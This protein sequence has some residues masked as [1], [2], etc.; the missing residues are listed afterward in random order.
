MCNLQ[1]LIKQELSMKPTPLITVLA[2]LGLASIGPA[3]AHVSLEVPGA[4][5]GST[6]KAVLRVP[7]GCDGKAT[8][9]VKVRIPEGFINVK[10]MPKAGWDLQTVVSTYQGS[11]ELHGNTLTEGVTEVVWSGGELPDAY[12]D[13][14]V[15][16]GTV[17]A[18]VPEGTT[19]FFP[20]VQLCDGAEEAWIDVTGAEDAEMPAP[21]LELAP[22]GATH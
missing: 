2:V 13:E 20:T 9:A 21:S 7:H 17:A 6:Y 4:T 12:Y 16:R 18:T 10:P 15:F 11:Y 19:F 22:A 1:P 14:F 8:T 5:I 3:A